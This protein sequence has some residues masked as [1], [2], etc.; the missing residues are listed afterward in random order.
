MID[1]SDAFEADE[2]TKV[3][4]RKEAIVNDLPAVFEEWSWDGIYAKSCIFMTK[5]TKTMTDESLAEMVES[6]MKMKCIG[7]Y[8]ITRGETFT[9]LNYDFFC[10]DAE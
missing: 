10:D 1:Y 5:D 6:H 4:Y 2:D 7:A 8:T 9:F 3:F